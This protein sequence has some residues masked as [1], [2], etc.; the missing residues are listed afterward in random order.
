MTLN[1]TKISL[2]DIK[3]C[4]ETPLAPYVTLDDCGMPLQDFRRIVAQRIL[5]D[6]KAAGIKARPP[7][8]PALAGAALRPK[9]DARDQEIKDQR[10]KIWDART[11]PRVGD[12]VIMPDGQTLRFAHDWGEDIQ[13]TSRMFHG[14]SSF[15]FSGTCSHSGALD[16]AIPK[17]CLSDTG[18]LRLGPV[19]FFHHDHASARNGVRTTIPCRVYRYVPAQAATNPETSAH[20]PD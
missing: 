9:F 10:L 5:D 1:H 17:T 8:N 13:T 20:A 3:A 14:D 11:G 16:D 12:F 18:E 4:R 19:W 6:Q 15:Y 7:S 2:A